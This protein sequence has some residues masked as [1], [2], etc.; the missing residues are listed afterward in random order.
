MTILWHH[1][2]LFLKQVPCVSLMTVITC[3][4]PGIPANGLRFGDDITVGQNVTFLCQ[5]GYVMVGGDNSVTITCTNNGTWSGTVPACQG[6]YQLQMR[7]LSYTAW[8][9]HCSRQSTLITIRPCCSN[10]AMPA[11]CHI[12]YK[13]MLYTLRSNEIS[14]Q[15]DTELPMW[16]QRVLFFT[17][18]CSYGR[19]NNT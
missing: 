4:D 19:V 16:S 10:P 12:Q 3:G 8:Y 1:V 5:P 2:K 9:T 13:Y 14:K 11:H 6:K 7:T 18:V 15:G 17:S